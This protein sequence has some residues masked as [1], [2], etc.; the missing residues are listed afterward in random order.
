MSPI[1]KPLYSHQ[2]TILSPDCKAWA[3]PPGVG[4][5]DAALHGRPL[6]VWWS[7][8]V[9]LL[10]SKTHEPYGARGKF[11]AERNAWVKLLYAHGSTGDAGARPLLS[12]CTCRRSQRPCRYATVGNA[13]APE[14][15]V[16]PLS[17]GGG[18]VSGSGIQPGY[19]VVDFGADKGTA[20]TILLRS[21]G[22]H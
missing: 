9:A 20:D 22:T 21:T 2:S 14:I 5:N 4:L 18:Y 1:L 8:H 10:D 19:V 15:E 13:G 16:P 6:A 11:Q 3:Q 12:G 7:M 17:A